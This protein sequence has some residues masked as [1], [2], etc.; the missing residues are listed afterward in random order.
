[1]T[2]YIAGRRRRQTPSEVTTKENPKSEARNPKQSSKPNNSKPEK[3][4]IPKR[5]GNRK[6]CDSRKGAKGAKEF[7]GKARDFPNSSIDLG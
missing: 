4:E 3:F 6:N 5:Q 7:I 2:L 1:M